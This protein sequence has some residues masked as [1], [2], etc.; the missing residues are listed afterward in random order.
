MAVANVISGNA[1]VGLQMGGGTA[2]QVTNNLIGVAASGRTA[3]GNGQQGVLVSG[4]SL[5][6]IL[7]NVISANGSDGVL[8][9]AGSDNNTLVTNLIGVDSTG[10][11]PL[12]NGGAGVRIGSSHNTIGPRPAVVG[13]VSNV[14]AYNTGG[15]IVVIG[16]A[17]N[18][19]SANSIFSNG[20]LGIDLGADG[21][22]PNDAKDADAGP[23]NLQNFPVLTSVTTDS[24][25]SHLSGTLNST[26]NRTFRIE[27]FESPV[28]N[29]SGYGPGQN[30]LL[31]LN[32]TTD[33]SGNAVFSNA[34][35]PAVPGG[36]VI[37]AT[38]TDN[39]TGDTSEFSAALHTS[40]LPGDTNGD[41]TVNFS[42]LLALAQHYGQS[43]G[44]SL[45]TGDVNGDG[46]V[47]FNDLLILAQNYGRTRTRR[48]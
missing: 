8:L 26:P 33:A 45:T 16:G 47:D 37:T 19:L 32:V 12:G 31:S 24:S 38:A 17:G 9:G 22:T 5:A 46:K 43:S 42:D 48:A 29:P 36:Q 25:G 15:G 1:T 13:S 3:L 34:L 41:G 21:V 35:L 2:T 6:S 23:N 39:V 10:V 7:G 44:M 20:N 18:T 14:I 11:A 28:P 40:G 27:V 4:G 30:Y